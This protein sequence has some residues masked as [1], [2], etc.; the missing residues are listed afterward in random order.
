VVHHNIRLPAAR[1]LGIDYETL[2][3]VKPDLI[4]GHVS[5]YGPTGP[6][7]DWPG[8]DQLAQAQCGWEVAGAGEGNP[9]VWHAFGMM[10]YQGAFQSLIAT[11]LALYHRF[12]IGEGQAVAGS[13]LG[14]GTL[15]MSELL[16]HPDGTLSEFLPLDHEQ[17]GVSPGVRI[18]QAADG[19]VA[20]AARDEGTFERAWRCLGL[21]H[22]SGLEEA[23]RGLASDEAVARWDEA[24]VPADL[25]MVAAA[26]PFF[27]DPRN[28]EVG[29]V[30]SYP[31]PVY[32][33]LVQIGKL[34][35]FGDLEVQIR[36]APPERGQH[37]REILLEAGVDEATIDSLVAGS[38]V[39]D[40]PEGLRA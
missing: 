33:T 4:F 16:V 34:W 24:G 35:D 7:A 8:F 18:Y 11:L 6:R 36:R 27:E 13:I 28:I 29:L 20:L 15:T 10:D 26:Q 31:H 40:N 5:N 38:T 9:P 21:G 17:T 2:R 37:S 14:G 25:V 1:R 19:W 39:V 12:R 22:P 32:E 3:Q 30:A 23:V